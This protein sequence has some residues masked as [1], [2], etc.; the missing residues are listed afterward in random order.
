MWEFLKKIFSQKDREVT[1]VML[2][3]SDPEISSSFNIRASG[4]I[5][6]ALIVVVISILL[7]TLIFLITPLGSLYQYQQDESLRREIINITEQVISLRDSLD[8]Q[9]QQL[10]DLKQVLIRNPDTTFS[11]QFTA[12]G[13]MNEEFPNQYPSPFQTESMQAFEMMS[14]NEIIFSDILKNIPDFPT[15][16]P[17]DGELTQ[18]FS[19]EDEHYGID[20]A[21]NEDSEFMAIADGTVVNAG[22][23]INFGYVIYV[24]HGN[25][26]MSVY[27]H[28]SR[29]VKRKGD[30]V[31]KGDILGIVGDTG[32]LSYG[33]HLHFEIWKNGVAQDPLMYLI[34]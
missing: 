18:E 28:G 27:K 24:Q 3:D 12:I 29:L 13:E 32:V 14:Q 16:F 4:M 20:L 31:L 19:S 21:A 1:V 8:A 6:L 11:S 23:T 7:T 34:K 22:W 17:V 10:Y 15:M 33:P 9:D 30:I 2:D 26:Y 5:K 25:G